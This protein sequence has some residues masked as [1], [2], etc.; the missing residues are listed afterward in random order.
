MYETHGLRPEDFR[1]QWPHQLRTLLIVSAELQSHSKALH[2]WSAACTKSATLDLDAARAA[3]GEETARMIS[4]IKTAHSDSSQDL[5][6]AT[7]E[8][9]SALNSYVKEKER[10]RGEMMGHSKHLVQQQRALHRERS[11]IMT[12]PWWKRAWIAIF[13]DAL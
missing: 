12:L 5:K 8:L 10:I 13:S 9:L 2:D 7:A 11:R 1:T 4:D 6:T 3:L